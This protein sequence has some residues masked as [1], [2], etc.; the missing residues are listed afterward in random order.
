MKTISWKSIEEKTRALNLKSDDFDLVVAISRDGIP[1]GNLLSK[2]LGIPM[3]TISLRFYKDEMPPKK[4]FEKPELLEKPEFE[5]E[6]KKILLADKLCRTGLTMNKAIQV[7]EKAKAKE[8]VPIAIAGE[9]DFCLFKTN[10]CF[11]CLPSREQCIE[12]LKKYELPPHIIRH[13]EAVEKLAV[14]LAK[15][16]NAKGISVNTELVSRISLL[17]DIDKMQTLK[18]GFEHL[19]SKLSKEILEKEGFPLIGKMVSKH[20]LE[21]VLEEKPFENWEEK[22]L[23][24]SDKRVNHDQIVSLQE[25]F[26]YLLDRYG[27]EKKIFDRISACKPGAEELEKEIFSNLDITSSLEGL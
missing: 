8:I 2:E 22:L 15:K 24:Y 5:I 21:N 26:D 23:L 6:G 10:E 11:E 1:F 9:K 20:L 25:R 3:E 18:P 12:L 14:F 17:H 13:S 16:F 4:E 7:L 27:K 19:H